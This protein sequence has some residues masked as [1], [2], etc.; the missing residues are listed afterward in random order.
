MRALRESADRTPP[1]RERYVDLLRALAICAVVLGHWLVS[2]IIEDPQGRPIGRSALESLP[3]AYPITWIV[4]VMPVFFIIGG[5][6]NAASLASH[7]GRGGDGVSW[8]Q[9][10]AARLVRPTTVLLTVLAV[11]A[12]AARV[13]RVDPEYIRMAVWVAS[14]P[15]WFLAAYLVVVAAAPVMQRLH[16]RYGLRVIAVLVVLV[17]LGDLARL[18]GLELLGAG[19][20]L[21]GWLAV[22][23]VGIVWR[24]GRLPFRPRVWVPLLLGGLAAALLLTVVGP[25]SISMIDV[26]GQRP[27]N[28]TPPTLA[29]LAVATFQLGLLMAV[30]DPAERWLHRRRPW[31]AVVAVNSVVFTIF[32]WHMSAVVLLVGVLDTLGVLPMPVVATTEWWLW[33]LPWLLLLTVVLIGL[34]ALFGPIEARSRRIRRRRSP[35]WLS[36]IVTRPM[37]RAVATV[38]AYAA[39]IAGL[40]SNTVA[41]RTGAHLVGLP[42]AGL[43]SYLAGAAI[44]HRLRSLPAPG[45]GD[46]PAPGTG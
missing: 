43:A 11:G 33:R 44:L 19:N 39:V 40:V 46:E 28:A 25:Y 45:R 37:L 41:S 18:N 2:A 17:A 24:D 12:V 23:Q 9:D 38:A 4:Q 15:L 5:Y 35:E 26:G 32:L 13:L 1:S 6:A 16:Q 29:L 42:T 30:R 22:H 20:F 10:R 8:L 34:V 27:R 7:R 36:R 14:I 21:F 31:L 3:W